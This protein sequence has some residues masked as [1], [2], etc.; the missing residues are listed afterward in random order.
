MIAHLDH[1][2]AAYPGGQLVASLFVPAMARSFT[3][4]SRPSTGAD[5]VPSEA[6]IQCRKHLPQ[7]AATGTPIVHAAGRVLRAP[8]SRPPGDGVR[9]CVRHRTSDPLRVSRPLQISQSA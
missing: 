6:R 7:A 3:R 2:L 8:L 4:R 1:E 5:G 9:G